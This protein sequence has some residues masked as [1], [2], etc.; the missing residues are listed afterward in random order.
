MAANSAESMDNGVRP[1]GTISIGIVPLA[2]TL[3]LAF[4]SAHASTQ[5]ALL[6]G[7]GEYADASM[8]LLGPPH[9]V[10]VLREQLIDNLG[11]PADQVRTLVDGQ[12]THANILRAL[13]RLRDISRSGDFVLVYLSGHGT[14]AF[15][16]ASA[17]LALPSGTGAFVPHDYKL[18][19]DAAEKLASLV[20]GF[21][22]LRPTLTTMDAAGVSGVVM[23][24]SCYAERTSRSL[25]VAD[26]LAWRHVT[27]GL[28]HLEPFDAIPKETTDSYPYRNLATLTAS[29]AKEKA[30]DLPNGA[31]TLDGLPHGAFTDALLRTLRDA[32]WTDANGDGVLTTW[33][34]FADLKQRMSAA[35]LPHSPQLLPSPG[36]DSAGLLARAAFRAAGY[37]ARPLEPQGESLRIRVDGKLPLIEAAIAQTPNLDSATDDHDLRV[38]RTDGVVRILTAFGDAVTSLELETD[39]AGALRQQPWIRSLVRNLGRE[40]GSGMELRLRGETYEAGDELR[41]A[42]TAAQRVHL[43]VLDIA[44]NGELRVLYPGR[45]DGFEAIPANRAVPF[46]AKVDAPFGI[47]YVLAAGFLAKPAFYDARLL[48]GAIKPHASLHR[49]LLTALQGGLSASVAVAKVVTVPRSPTVNSKAGG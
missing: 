13:E 48:A 29:S 35:D 23:V 46:R 7:V 44:P 10:A 41:I 40:S 38:V 16:P 21:R 43:L 1:R 8:R 49:E 33:E 11:F 25:H 32:A 31:M 19:G 18:R 45:G 28:E 24:D 42:A 14:S 39:A 34:L 5:R 9:D 2:L 27:S 26:S 36:E 17:D 4:G 3:T 30:L 37:A 12:A 22:D 6:V 47:D 15:N 20:I